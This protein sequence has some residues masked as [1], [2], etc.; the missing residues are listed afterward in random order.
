MELQGPS[1]KQIGIGN[2]DEVLVPLKQISN[3]VQVIISS[4][5]SEVI[6]FS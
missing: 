3:A 5:I 2:I 4:F 6:S 1:N